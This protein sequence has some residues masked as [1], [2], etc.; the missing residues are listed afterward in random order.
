MRVAWRIFRCGATAM[1]HGGSVTS[2]MQVFLK[3][4]CFD[5]T[6]VSHDDLIVV[7]GVAAPMAICLQCTSGVAR[8]AS[9][10]RRQSHCLCPRM[11]IGLS[12]SEDTGFH[13]DA[14]L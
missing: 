13:T 12:L 10:P 5:V 11:N 7:L 1:L 9:Y 8:T 3:L 4:S 14:M 2:A 6:T